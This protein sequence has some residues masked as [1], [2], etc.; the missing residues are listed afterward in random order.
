MS[1]ALIKGGHVEPELAD[2]TM[3]ARKRRK[4][5][6]SI[7]GD[8]PLYDTGRLVKSIRF[9]KED[10][11]IKAVDY[12]KG[13]IDGTHKDWNGKPVH[14]RDFVTQMHEKRKS[15]G[16]LADRF[17]QSKTEK[18]LISK[19]KQKFSRRLAR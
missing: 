11:S 5:P 12:A 8:K 2:A 14:K 10:L 3:K 19:I 15:A 6:P 9:D 16:M 13:H 18:M 4:F 17:A 1:K 7:G